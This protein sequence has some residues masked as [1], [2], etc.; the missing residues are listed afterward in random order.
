LF[1]LFED[2][3]RAFDGAYQASVIASAVGK[4]MSMDV[5]M[6]IHELA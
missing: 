6:W 1:Q 2:M 5:N 3:A 4:D